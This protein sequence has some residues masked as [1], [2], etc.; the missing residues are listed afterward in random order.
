MKN[1]L[2]ILFMFMFTYSDTLIVS[3]P[4]KYGASTHYL[5]IKVDTNYVYTADTKVPLVLS[6]YGLD[7][8]LK[9]C[10]DTVNYTD[11]VLTT[12][13]GSAVP[14][15]VITKPFQC[16]LQ[17]PA[18]SALTG[19]TLL[20]GQVGGTAGGQNGVAI[21]QDIHGGTDDV[22]L[23]ITGDTAGGKLIDISKN[24]TATD[25]N[26]VYGSA[27]K[28]GKCAEFN[29]NNSSSSYPV[30][31][32]TSAYKFSVNLWFN[33]DVAN[34][35][36]YFIVAPNLTRV[37]TY[38]DGK[39]YCEY[40]SLGTKY[41]VKSAYIDS[42]PATEF[43]M[44]TLIFDSTQTANNRFR[45]AR[46]GKVSSFNTYVGGAVPARLSAAINNF[47]LGNTG[48]AFD[49][50]LD[51]VQLYTGVWSENQIKLI[52][53]N[54]NTYSTN[55]V[56]MLGAAFS[57]NEPTIIDSIS[58]IKIKRLDTLTYYLTNLI[59]STSTIFAKINNFSLDIIQWSSEIVKAIIP[60]STPR[61]TYTNPWIGY[62]PD[63]TLGLDTAITS[64]K[65]FV[66][67]FITDGGN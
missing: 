62:V 64:L 65:C 43:T 17:D 33:Q 45:Y 15:T 18:Q 41:A 40:D 21:W 59:D 29:G 61:G 36:D 10:S 34:Q 53:A 38:T 3:A 22:F 7:S 39:M 23:S 37:Y 27:G 42:F 47:M 67:R 57:Y 54:Q 52:Y 25:A 51:E 35:I 63:D 20:Y 32:L 26:L 58:P 11:F 1:L 46:N 31:Q 6:G 60:D 55:G 49:G 28:I 5:P 2:F 44:M 13:V 30:T 50:K 9:H 56:F 66:P 24:Y 14:C 8:L 12:A 16:Y 19:G 48:S 4:V